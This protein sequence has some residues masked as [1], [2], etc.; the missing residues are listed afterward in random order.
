[1][2]TCASRIPLALS[3]TAGLAIC[4]SLVVLLD[5]PDR[6]P[7]AP[8]PAQPGPSRGAMPRSRE[9]TA[10]LSWIFEHR[11]D[12]TALEFLSWSPARS[13]ADNPF[14]K[15]PATLVQ[16]VV[17][18]GSAADEKLEYLSFYLHDLDV[19]GSISKPYPDVM[20]AV[21]A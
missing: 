15:G 21:C 16:L 9:H 20:T 5:Q 8:P 1:M 13:V 12:A 18:N 4:A 3:F 14:T 11:P 2:I 10:V 17:K 6:E 19:L 7:A